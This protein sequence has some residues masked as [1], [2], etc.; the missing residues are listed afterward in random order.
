M[1]RRQGYSDTATAVGLE[2]SPCGSAIGSRFCG[3][4]LALQSA[5]R[6]PQDGDLSGFP[7]GADAHV[8]IHRKA[9][10]CS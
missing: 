5:Y 8:L 2:L 6:R 10:A 7:T 4:A 3:S 1:Q 9:R